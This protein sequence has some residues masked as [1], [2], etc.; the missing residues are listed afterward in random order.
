VQVSDISLADVARIYAGELSAWPG[1]MPIRLIRRPPTEAD[2]QALNALSPSMSAAA[3]LAARRQ[4]LLTAATDQDNVE[5][6][7]TVP[8]AF[9]LVSLGQLVAEDASIK[10]LSLDG[11]AP[12]LAAL[13]GG[14]WPMSRELRLVTLA[15]S[16]DVQ[17]FIAYVQGPEGSVVLNSLGYLPVT[18]SQ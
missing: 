16:P 11:V 4:G 13:A 3:A 2:W 15:P 6:I 14:Q 1:G 18:E 9:G 5:T 10:P 17:D 7:A 12:S 8:G